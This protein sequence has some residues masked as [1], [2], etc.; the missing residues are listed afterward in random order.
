M[1]CPG[2]TTPDIRNS[3]VLGHVIQCFFSTVCCVCC[4]FLKKKTTTKGSL[5]ALCLDELVHS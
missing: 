2:G 5:K 1:S 4:I 3:V